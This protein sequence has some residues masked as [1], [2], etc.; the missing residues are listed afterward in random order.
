MRKIAFQI[1]KKRSKN[2]RSHK[3]QIL[4][5]NAKNDRSIKFKNALL[6]QQ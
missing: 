4:R 1:Q 2:Y 6:T 3:V 5:E